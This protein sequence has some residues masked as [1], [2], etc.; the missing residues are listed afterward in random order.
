MAET[1][2]GKQPPKRGRALRWLGWTGG[3][4]VVLV[5]AL[6]FVASSSAFVKGFIVPKAGAVLN[7]D[8]SLAD[9]QVSPFSQVVLRELKL[10]PKGAETLLVARELRA[11]YS[12]WSMLGGRIVVE[13]VALVA[14]VITIVKNADGTSNLD[15]LTEK[16]PGQPKAAPKPAAAP[17][18]P[19]IVDIK[20]VSV[21]DATL[22]LVTH[23]PEGGRDTIEVSG[24]KLT[25]SNI[26]NGQTGKLEL[27]AGLSVDQ[28]AR[29]EIAAASLVAKLAGAFTFELT[30]E[31]KPGSAKGDA[32][33]QVEKAAG[34]LEDFGSLAAKLDCEVTPS[35]I[36]QLALRFN[37]AADSL[38]ELRLSGPFDPA[39][40]EGRLKAELTSL[41][42]KLL[43]LFGAA[44]GI[45]FGTTTVS[46]V[47]NLELAKGGQRLGAVGQFNVGRFQ[48]TRQNQT[49]PTLDLAFDYDVTVDRAGE[50]ATI[51][52]LDL[53]GMQNGQP[54]LEGGL[55]SPMTIA[56]GSASS[57][58]GDAALT[59]SLTGLNLA[60]WRAFAAELAPAG[61]ASAKLKLL[62]QQAGK[63]LTFELD[64]QLANFSAR[65]GS[66]QLDRLD[67]RVALLGDAAELKR[68][69]LADYRL[70]LAQQGQNALT[71][72]GSGTFDSATQDADLQVIA[73]ATLAR[74]LALLPQP[75]AEIN[76]G[77]LD[78]KGR[79]VGKDKAQAVT[80][81][82]ALADFS[83]RYGDYR[84][85]RFGA[86]LE[87][88]LALKGNAADVR[89]ATGT[90]REG[91]KPG[92]RFEANGSFDLEKKAGR[93]A[94]KLA[95][96]N[97]YGLRPFIESA[98]G[99]KKLVSV[100]LNTTASGTFEANGDAAVK[101]EL[102]V[103]NLVVSDPKGAIPSTPLEAR[104]QL[105][106]A[107]SK[108]VANVRQCQLALTPSERANNQLGLTGSVDYSKSN[109][110]TGSL[111]LAAEALDVTRYYDLFAG[112]PKSPETAKSAPSNPPMP[113]SDPT[114]EPDPMILPFRNFTL[115]AAIGR[116][117]LREVDIANVQATARI[118]GGHLV[119]KPCQLTLN[120]APVSATS[121]LDL[122][123]PGYKY[124][125]VLDARAV[126]LAPLVNSFLPERK[127]QI[128]GT[129][130]ANAQIQ[131]AGVTGTSLQK[132][133]TGQF[134]FLSTN[135][136][137]SI[138]NV[139]NP[140]LNSV[141]NV[142]IGIPDLIR[143]PAAALGNLLS[144]LATGSK[145]KG[146]W[147]DDLTASPI[148]VILARGKAGGGR[149][150]LEQTEVRSRAFQAEAKGSITLAPVLT[151]SP[152]HIP[153]NLSLSQA[154]GGKIGLVTAA[155]PTNAPYVPMPQFLTMKGTVGDPKSDINKLVL[156][157]LGA[158]AGG[159]MAQ[160]V[161]GTKGEQVGSILQGV[162]ALLG[163]GAS[164]APS[165]NAPAAGKTNAPTT[166]ATNQPPADSVGN[167]IRGLDSL[168]GG[169]RTAP[170]QTNQP[171]RPR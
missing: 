72:S 164:P 38:G 170:A 53:K 93:I 138:A 169:R 161:G 30:E 5:V 25:V 19:P 15:P 112:A 133:L 88:D 132:N 109:A 16:P 148:D 84:F 28:A 115:E 141:I 156:V 21:G 103:T 47:S 151:N 140:L 77:A 69:T 158:K 147:A 130:T 160:Q 67:L 49:T 32:T 97:Q 14:P 8:L 120:G 159:S 150:D 79:V 55:T 9:A 50:L 85:A 125:V 166:T 48:V 139:R 66:N 12:L 122:G 39:K 71:V 98:L 135:L 65:L 63:K 89:K 17:G 124:D 35:E 127:G 7:A 118:D 83:G 114:K 108:N 107:V 41:D 136:N 167:L 74:L 126:P 128:G 54:L 165:T 6:Y 57:A 153:V 26:K 155:T 51:A 113:A 116:F 104:L 11:R 102:S 105:D 45:D 64:S 78:F 4:L 36:K 134:G 157:A 62:S 29:K 18:K 146:G 163:G 46:A 20:S 44:N 171:A 13:E 34:N 23:L 101:A 40:M 145:P 149:V 95:D 152:I 59:L 31:L 75:G 162:G 106:T 68:F 168:L 3:V 33:F 61:V 90:L 99:D 131:G 43:N 24:A 58:V 111:K 119:L 10:T 70:D 52:R 80:G 86:G 143:N 142:I 60:D 92:G 27:A 117:Y 37:R 121:D 94:L 110:I 96:F 1:Q 56:W 87:L 42:R 82:L 76:A 73:K 123:I 144:G 2:A 154:L 81:Q 100:E 129:T 137:L 91:D 22:R